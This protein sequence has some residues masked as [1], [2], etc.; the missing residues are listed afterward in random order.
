[1]PA[2]TVEADDGTNFAATPAGDLEFIWDHTTGGNGDTRQL[3]I[4][5]V[6]DGPY[7]GTE[8]VIHSYVST[9][10][11]HEFFAFAGN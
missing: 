6:K 11:W 7:G 4:K 10:I 2:W 3:T 5:R 8:F 9:T 1:M